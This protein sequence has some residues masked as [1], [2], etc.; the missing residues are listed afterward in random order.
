MPTQ[1]SKKGYFITIEGIDAVGKSTQA[2]LLADKLSQLGIPRMKVREPG[3]TPICEDIR[4][5]LKRGHTLAPIAELF[6]FNAARNQLVEEVINPTLETATVIICDRFLDSTVAYQH[7]GN[8]LDWTMVSNVVCYAVHGT[9]PDLTIWLDLQNEERLIRLA[10]SNSD[11]IAKY[12]NAKED[13][14]ARLVNGFATIAH[15]NQ[16]RVVRIESVGTPEEVHAKIWTVAEARLQ[17]SGFFDR[18]NTQSQTAPVA[19]TAMTGPTT[20]S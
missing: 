12:D 1:P 8:G 13:Y 3:G 17:A 6:L 9:L 19:T 18:L 14:V 11:G 4:N 20:P 2:A 15:W 16:D 7:Y 10:K 5:I